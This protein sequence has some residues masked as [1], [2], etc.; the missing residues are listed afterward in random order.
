[1]DELK[2]LEKWYLKN[3]NGDWEH[4]YGIKI[5]TLDNPGWSLD[6]DLVDTNLE[7]KYFDAIK[8]DRSENDWLHCRIV[9]GVFKGRGGV[10]NLTELIKVFCKWA[11]SG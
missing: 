7:P 9:D 4:S 1:M 8:I 6:I 3:C 11:E 5:S 10:Q 2:W